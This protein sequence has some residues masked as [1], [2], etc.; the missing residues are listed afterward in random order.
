MNL[1]LVAVALTLTYGAPVG[2]EFRG[3]EFR[4]EEFQGEEF[5]GEGFRGKDQN[6]CPTGQAIGPFVV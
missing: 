4:G 2:E 1:C 6:R 5:R 3:E